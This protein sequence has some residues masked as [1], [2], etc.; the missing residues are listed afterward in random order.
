MPRTCVSEAF[1]KNGGAAE[2][3]AAPATFSAEQLGGALAG[4]L[5]AQ[6]ILVVGR[7]RAQFPAARGRGGG[8]RA[9]G[10]RTTGTPN[11]KPE[12]IVIFLDVAEIILPCGAEQG[13]CVL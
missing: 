6:S 4:F 1:R 12:E 5:Q 9:R 3:T 2:R 7:C 11:R 13:G 10:G 8:R